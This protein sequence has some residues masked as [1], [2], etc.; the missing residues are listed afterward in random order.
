M[1]RF[2]YKIGLYILLFITSLYIFWFS[3]L[4][5]IKV[6]FINGLYYTVYMFYKNSIHEAIR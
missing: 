4:K 2:I 1:L 5:N 6:F 3:K